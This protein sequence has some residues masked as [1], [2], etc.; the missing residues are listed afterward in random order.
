MMTKPSIVFIR[1]AG[2][3]FDRD[4]IGKWLANEFELVG[5]LIIESDRRRQFNTVK[6]E[7]KRSGASGLID[8]FT[9]RA[10]YSLRISNGEDEKIDQLI[11]EHSARFEPYST[12]TY[13]IE[14]PNT[15]EAHRILSDLAPDV[16][17]ARTKVLLNERIFSIPKHG[18]FVI[19]PGICPEYRNQ[20]GCFWALAMGDDQKVGYSLI[21][22]DDGIDTGEIY[23]QGGTSFNPQEDEHIYIQFKVVADNLNQIQ[24]CIK[25]VVEE[26]GE[27]IDTRGRQSALWGMPKLTAWLTWKRRVDKFDITKVDS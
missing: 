27:S 21:S 13:R 10:L 25:S 4:V 19:H 12:E 5:E 9:F 15:D 26:S 24:D 18:T 20:H 1:H 22:I 6:H 16:M 3:R 11:N 8:A 2:S 17:V 14:D 23:A 7:Y